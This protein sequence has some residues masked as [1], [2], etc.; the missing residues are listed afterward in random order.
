MA[1][2]DTNKETKI[3]NESIVKI[4][5]DGNTVLSDRLEPGEKLAPSGRDE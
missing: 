4:D 5:K 1:K 2:A 3:F